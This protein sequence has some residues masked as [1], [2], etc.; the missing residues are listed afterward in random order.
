MKARAFAPLFILIADSIGLGMIVRHVVLGRNGNNHPLNFYQREHQNEHLHACLKRL[1][2]AHPRGCKNSVTC[3]RSR[4]MRLEALTVRSLSQRTSMAQDDQ[5]MSVFTH[6]EPFSACGDRL[7]TTRSRLSRRGFSVSRCHFRSACDALPARV[8]A[9]RLGHNCLRATRLAHADDFERNVGQRNIDPASLDVAPTWA[10]L[11]KAAK[12]FLP[13]LASRAHGTPTSPP[14]RLAG[15]VYVLFDGKT[16]L[17]KIG[18]TKTAGQRQRVQMAGLGSALVNV[19]NAR[20]ADCLT[21]ETSVTII[22][23]VLHEW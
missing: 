20:V 15:Y 22:F 18:H 13:H 19:V 17:G 7:K 6:S 11:V 12:Q 16:G 9:L 23:P 2:L 8:G 4:P 1:A 5:V 10:H 21:A 14:D 3:S